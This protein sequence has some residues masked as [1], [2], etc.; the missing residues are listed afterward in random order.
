[1]W[2]PVC[3]D[4]KECTR[5]TEA[6]LVVP[7]NTAVNTLEIYERVG[8]YKR[9]GDHRMALYSVDLCEEDLRVTGE[10]AVYEEE[11]EEVEGGRVDWRC[12][13]FV[14]VASLV[15]GSPKHDDPGDSEYK[16]VTDWL[17]TAEQEWPGEPDRRS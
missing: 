14:P 3:Q 7:S 15:D 16:A 12:L 17:E 2:V 4:G 11:G 8:A 1:M 9:S 13:S 5:G 10:G 6:A